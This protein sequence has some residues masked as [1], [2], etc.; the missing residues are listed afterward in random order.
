M[1]IG[2]DLPEELQ[3]KIAT[4]SKRLEFLD[5]KFVEPQ[6]L[7]VN[8]KFL[9]EVDESQLEAIKNA[10]MSIQDSFEPFNIKIK[11][12]GSFP[13]MNYINVVWLGIESGE[14]EAIASLLDQKLVLVGFAA[15]HKELKLH[16]TLCRVKSDRNLDKFR[17]LYKELQSIEVGTFQVDQIHLF[18]STLTPS[19][20]VYEKV[21]TVRL[22][23]S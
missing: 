18:K 11:E 21:F 16:L 10:L 15:D 12:L 3:S 5:G 23:G 17:D 7:H 19:G 8:L 22:G 2:A 4:L 1:F 9:G 14:M 6:N 13:S 20:P